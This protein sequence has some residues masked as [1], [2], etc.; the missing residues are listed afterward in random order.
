[1]PFSPAAFATVKPVGTPF[2][3]RPS[4]IRVFVED[5]ISIVWLDV[6]R[7]SA[8]AVAACAV[9]EGVAEAEGAADF[10]VVAAG[11]S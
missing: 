3:S 8:F 10:V 7:V 5:L 11:T 2:A 9:S 6:A 4:K 1:M